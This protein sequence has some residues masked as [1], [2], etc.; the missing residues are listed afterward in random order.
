MIDVDEIGEKTVDTIKDVTSYI[1][2]GLLGAG[3]VSIVFVMHFIPKRDQIKDAANKLN[4]FKLL[5]EMEA[6]KREHELAMKRT[7]EDYESAL[8]RAKKV[9]PVET[10][11]AVVRGE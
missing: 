6:Q 2:C 4:F 8:A 5:K 11:N 1:A 10:M 7:K 9:D 3:L